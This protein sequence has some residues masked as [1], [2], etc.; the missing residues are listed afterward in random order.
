MGLPMATDQSPD[1]ENIGRRFSIE[2]EFVSAV[3]YGTGHIHDSYAA[4]YNI[5]GQQRRFLF[6]W[7]NQHVFKDPAAVMSNVSRVTAHLRSKVEAQ[8]SGEVGRRNL[9]LV[10]TREGNTYWHDGD[11]EYWRVYEFIEGAQSYE[12]VRSPDHAEA[13]ARAY[14]HFQRLLDDLPG[15]RLIET[16]LEF[17]HTP[18]RYRTFEEAIAKDLAGRA[19]SVRRE[20]D[21]ALARKELSTR[22]VD[23]QSRG[24]I[25]E[26]V[27]HNDTK[28][29]NVLIDDTTGEGICVVDLDTVM[30]GVALYDFGDMVRAG[31]NPAA[32][33]ETNL[34]LVNMQLPL[35]EAL[36]KGY[37][38]SA[39]G[40]LVP[41]ELAQLA[42]SGLLITLQQGVR[43]LTDHLEDDHYFRTT[44]ENHN[45]DRARTQFK[46]VESMEAQAEQM[47]VVIAKAISAK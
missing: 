4:T 46:L 30:P 27:V 40:F 26:R 18:S 2:G 12:V 7:I 31:T 38:S 43:F 36:V 3:M 24:E 8:G 10:P 25:P 47:E 9:T 34:D 45:L 1:I 6:Q 44:R 5:H 42:F 32:E 33:D 28:A 11:D 41:A 19:S 15:P 22:L 13:C 17:H 29:S 23:A 16:I 35:F 39:G 37:L 20:I 14:G 21:F